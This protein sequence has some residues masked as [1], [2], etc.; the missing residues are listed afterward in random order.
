M[1]RAL[2]VWGILA[3]LL[4]AVAPARAVE[5][6]LFEYALNLGGSLFGPNADP[7]PASVDLTGFDAGTGLGV[8]RVSAMGNATGQ[9]PYVG[10]FVDHEIDQSAT[11]FFGEEGEAVGAPAPSQS[12]EI[13][14][15]DFLFG[16]SFDN[17][18][19]SALDNTVFDG[20]SGISPDDISMALAWELSAPRFVWKELRFDFTVSQTAPTRF[21]LAQRNVFTDGELFFSSRFSVIPEPATL[22]LFAL[23]LA[24]MGFAGGRRYGK[25]SGGG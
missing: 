9:V 16:N 24:G 18:S 4:L 12:W 14:E 6:D 17:F 7:V 5:I 3:A 22:A 13:D 25:G 19:S 15:P 20:I 2:G 11:S 10:L 1:K 21:Y 8:I 23:G